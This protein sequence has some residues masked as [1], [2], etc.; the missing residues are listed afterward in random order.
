M[1]ER[2]TRELSGMFEAYREYGAAR[3]GVARHSWPLL[4]GAIM[5]AA[6]VALSKGG[7]VACVMSAAGLLAL[8]VLYTAAVGRR[9]AARIR[10]DAILDRKLSECAERNAE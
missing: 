4:L 6:A 2:T 10:L 7:P 3:R 5:C 9:T 8:M 1:D